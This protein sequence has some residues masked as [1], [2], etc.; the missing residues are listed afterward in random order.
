MTSRTGP[1]YVVDDDASVR[2]GIGRLLRSF[3]FAVEEFAAPEEFLERVRIHG[4]CCVVLDVH[5]PGLNGLDVQSR[6]AAVS[7][8]LQVVFITGNGDVPTSVRA[9]KA[10]AVDFL[11]KPFDAS[12]LIKA[13][14]EALVRSTRT[15]RAT[16]NLAALQKRWNTLTTRERE[17]FQ[18]V[19]S[20]LPNKQV[21]AKFGISEQTV[22]IHRGRVMRKMAAQSLAELVQSATVLGVIPGSGTLP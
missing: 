19:V 6:L 7:H 16:G 13:V 1:V 17:V 2:K 14:E 18:A 9:I 15:Y 5:L 22:K 11:L 21:A 3:G 20:G 10:G 12:A 4:P 8:Q